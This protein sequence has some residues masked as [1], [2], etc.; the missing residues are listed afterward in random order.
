MDYIEWMLEAEFFNIK[1]TGSTEVVVWQAVNSMR[2]PGLVISVSSRFSTWLRLYDFPSVYLLKLICDG[3]G[4]ICA[5]CDCGGR[6]KD[7]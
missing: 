2:S 5:Y 1:F 7:C 3:L 4:G 6:P